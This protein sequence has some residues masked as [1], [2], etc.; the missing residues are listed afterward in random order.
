MSNDKRTDM[1]SCSTQ[2]KLELKE[3]N[4]IRVIKNSNNKLG[5]FVSDNQRINGL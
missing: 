3:T 4:R 1:K 2:H 5:L